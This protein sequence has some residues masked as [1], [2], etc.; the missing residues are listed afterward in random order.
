MQHGDDWVF[1]VLLVLSFITL[2]YR[3]TAQRSHKQ[4]VSFFSQ[5]VQKINL[6]L[7]VLW[8]INQHWTNM[9]VLID[10]VQCLIHQYGKTDIINLIHE[11]R[12]ITITHRIQLSKS[13]SLLVLLLLHICYYTACL[14]Q[15]KLTDWI[16]TWENQEWIDDTNTNQVCFH[17][18]FKD[19][20]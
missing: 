7:A 19:E 6:L 13:K 10:F 12:T 20:D 3:Q 8:E 9:R 5:L 18:I 2:L 15:L 1:C 16:H 11:Q 14:C 4:T 17:V